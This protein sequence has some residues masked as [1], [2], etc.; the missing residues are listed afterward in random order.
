MSE[1]PSVGDFIYSFL[2]NSFSFDSK[3]F[4]TLKYLILYPGKLAFLFHE[5]RWMNVVHPM[6]V[7]LFTGLIFFTVQNL[8]LITPLL[9]DLSS[10]V[11]KNRDAFQ[12]NITLSDSYG[13]LLQII[14]KD[15]SSSPKLSA[16]TDSLIR[17]KRSCDLKTY[18]I[19][20]TTANDTAFYVGKDEMIVDTE[21]ANKIFGITRYDFNTLEYDSLYNKYRLDTIPLMKGVLTKQ[22]HKAY[23]DGAN[24]TA[25][26]ISKISWMILLTVPILALFMLILYHKRRNYKYADL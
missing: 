1:T 2:D 11:Q 4:R 23:R 10:D 7:F 12:S 3:F 5:G 17:W 16:L 14:D 26:I 25:Y 20:D 21:R 15:S 8:Y 19:V 13:N 6:R 24:L 9:S 18:K 22:A